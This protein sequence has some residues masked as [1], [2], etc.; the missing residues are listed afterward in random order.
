MERRG[1]VGRA[2]AFGAPRDRA[3]QRRT[4]R[5][6]APRPAEGPTADLGKKPCAD[7]SRGTFDIARDKRTFEPR[8][9]EA[10]PREGRIPARVS[11]TVL[12]VVRAID[13]AHEALTGRVEFRDEAP[14]QWHLSS[15]DDAQAMAANATGKH[16][17]FGKTRP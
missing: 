6:G 10:T 9:P 17:R 13:L 2:R 8:H 16:Y 7:E 11:A 5:Q 14:E 12:V 3:P 4:R 1:A 15:K